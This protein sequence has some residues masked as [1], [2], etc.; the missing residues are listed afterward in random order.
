MHP[1]YST[2]VFGLIFFHA[3]VQGRSKYGLWL[4]T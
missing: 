4:C 1:S 3:V 2:I